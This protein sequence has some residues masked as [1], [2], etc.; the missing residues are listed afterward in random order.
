MSPAALRPEA[1]LPALIGGKAA[2]KLSK[3]LDLHTV[4]DLL[5]HYPRRYAER[6][7]LTD[8]SSV[9]V[10]E[11]VTV[12]ARVSYATTRPMRKRK[13]FVTE[14]HVT[15]GSHTLVLTFFDTKDWRLKELP[16]VKDG[17]FAGKITRYRG[18]DRSMRGRGQL[19]HPE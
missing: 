19:V 1:P 14:V 12:L 7:Q 15:D 2:T 11:N 16:V 10:D 3:E 5:R 8:L 17:L 4:Q 9:P 6:G 18:P 13:G